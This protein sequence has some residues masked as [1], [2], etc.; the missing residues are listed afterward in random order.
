MRRII[1]V[2]TRPSPLIRGIRDNDY[3]S[4]LISDLYVTALAL[5]KTYSSFLQKRHSVVAAPINLHSGHQSIL[6]DTPSL[7][8]EYEPT[9]TKRASSRRSATT[10]LSVSNHKPTSSKKITPKSKPSRRRAVECFLE[11]VCCILNDMMSSVNHYYKVPLDI[12]VVDPNGIRSFQRSF[13]S[14]IPLRDAIRM[15]AGVSMSN[16]RV[17]R[18]HSILKSNPMVHELERNEKLVVYD[19]PD[20]QHNVDRLGKEQRLEIQ[21]ILYQSITGYPEPISRFIVELSRVNQKCSDSAWKETLPFTEHPQIAQKYRD[22]F[23]DEVSGQITVRVYSPFKTRSASITVRCSDSVGRLRRKIK[24]RMSV[25]CKD[26]MIFAV[27]DTTV[28]DMENMDGRNAVDDEEPISDQL[29][30]R[31]KMNV[32]LNKYK[33]RGLQ[34]FQLRC[35]DMK[36]SHFPLH[37]EKRTGS[38]VRTLMFCV[39]ML[40]AEEREDKMAIKEVYEWSVGYPLSFG[41]SDSDHVGSDTDESEFEEY[42]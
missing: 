5:Q 3:I 37:Y 20:D 8:I 24:K 10:M 35:D 30:L 18:R 32:I 14:Y 36:I 40:T 2:Q 38:S 12:I 7:E 23:V 17:I 26:L 34:F 41:S 13:A 15:L 1:A 31:Q 19:D 39:P 22:E 6:S 25:K 16:P 9:P 28:D 11:R 33:K 29:D 4:M 27:T 21:S 42:Y